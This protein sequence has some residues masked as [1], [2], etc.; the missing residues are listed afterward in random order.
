MKDYFRKYL[1]GRCSEDEFLS[2][3]NLFLKADKQKELTKNME[4][5]WKSVRANKKTPDLSP[6]LHKIHFEINKQEKSEN[7]TRKI[8]TYLTRI[9]AVLFIPLAVAFFFTVQKNTSSDVKNQTISTPLASKTNFELPDGSMVYL[10]AGSSLSFPEKF[11]GKKRLVKLSG[12][13]YFDVK[14]SK[15]PF[16]VE[17]SELTV[18]VLGTAFNVMAYQNTLPEVTLERGKVVVNTKSNL[19]KTLQPGEQAV[20]DITANTIS[21]NNVETELFTSWINNRLIFKNEM[22][23][24]V[25][26][27][28]ER[29]YNISIEIDNEPLEQKRINAT[30]E[31]ESISE[32]MEL[33]EITLPIKFEY[34]KN[35]RKLLIKSSRP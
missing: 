24:N 21:V 22:L 17:T 12:E 23:G 19:Q 31:Y 27:K 3:I 25:V 8:V 11:T 33:L 14:K 4:E 9:A 6:T 5:D 10:N 32:V 28:L 26:Q 35:E 18:N 29:W 16:E 30:I 13:A 2:F 1:E 34:K 15:Q 20:I 7:K